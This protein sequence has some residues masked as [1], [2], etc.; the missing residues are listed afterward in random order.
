MLLQPRVLL[1]QV[2]FFLHVGSCCGK[3]ETAPGIETARIYGNIYAYAYYFVDLLVGT[4]PQ[5]TSVILDTGS[6]VCAFTCTHC[7]RCGSHLDAAFDFNDSN[8]SNWIRCG[9][10][11]AGQCQKDHCSYF[12][13]YTEGSAIKGWWFDDFVSLGDAANKEQPNHP[14]RGRMGCHRLETNLFYTQEANGMLGV[15]P[16]FDSQEA[17]VTPLLQQLYKDSPRV[18]EHI[19]S[20]CLAE[21]GGMLAVGGFNVSYHTGPM[22]WI[23]MKDSGYYSVDLTGMQVNGEPVL[24]D[25]G[26]AIID[27]GTTYTYMGTTAYSAL[28]S[29]IVLYCQGHNGCGA[30]ENG[31][32]WKLPSAKAL[33]NFP[34]IQVLFGNVKTTWVPSAY[35]Y[36]RGNTKDWCY[37]FQDDGLGASTVLGASWMLKQEIVFNMEQKSVGIAQ[38]NCPEF[39]ITDRPKRSLMVTPSS[40]TFK[41]TSRLPVKLRVGKQEARREFAGPWHPAMIEGLV[42]LAGA[43]LALAVCLFATKASVSERNAASVPR[44]HVPLSQSDE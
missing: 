9:T 16:S 1:L 7:R 4:P 35:M 38:A 34:N 28:R 3:K 15:G 27:S 39:R 5:R 23:K 37:S 8:T 25:F 18:R 26:S 20:I 42:V 17:T 6:R 32:C 36:H 29:D 40:N 14:V 19:F 43:M 24:A 10:G 11:C 33:D 2:V 31:N 13:H 12:Q 41:S 30:R 44:E 22:Q 21:W